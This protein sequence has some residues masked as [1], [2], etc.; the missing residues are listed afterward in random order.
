MLHVTPQFVAALAVAT[1]T[2]LGCI[3]LGV[4]A[5]VIFPPR[6]TIGGWPYVVLCTIALAGAVFALTWTQVLAATLVGLV[7]GGIVVGLMH[8]AVRRLSK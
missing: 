2:Y 5:Q 8:L 7:N 4:A 6:V 3:Q 1:T